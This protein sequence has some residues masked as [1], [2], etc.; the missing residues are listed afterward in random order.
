MG[1]SRSA[2]SARVF[3]TSRVLGQ[4]LENSL[5]GVPAHIPFLQLA[6][7]WRNQWWTLISISPLFYDCV[8]QDSNLYMHQTYALSRIPHIPFFLQLARRWRNQW[9]TLIS[10]SLVFYDCVKQDTNL[11]MH[12]TYALSRILLV[13]SK[14]L[15]QLI[16]SEEE[17][18][19]GESRNDA[20]PEN[21]FERLGTRRNRKR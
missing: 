14:H 17:G 15:L 20:K 16:E 8:K 6:R 10:I 11:Y 9:W 13:S 5:A 7:R 1:R 21:D 4:E 19:Y 12:L 18:K 3:R 2:A